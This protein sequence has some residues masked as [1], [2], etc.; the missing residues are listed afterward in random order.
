VG[1][2]D[3]GW[4]SPPLS[5]TSNAAIV[6]YRRGIAALVAGLDHAEE[7]L[8]DAIAVDN[9]FYVARVGLAAVRAATGQA[10]I[11]PHPTRAARRGERQHGEIVAAAL[12]GDGRHAADLRREH[13]LEYPGDLLIVW[14]PA[15]VQLRR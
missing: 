10:Y 1:T 14:L 9:E 2:H 6:L 5:T 12:T 8:A 15:L 3:H 7:T 11:A 4:D 13:L